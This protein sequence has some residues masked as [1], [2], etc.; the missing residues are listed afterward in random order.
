[1]VLLTYRQ[2]DDDAQLLHSAISKAAT[3]YGRNT[4]P[5]SDE[6]PSRAPADLSALLHAM[7]GR[8]GSTPSDKVNAIALL[9]QKRGSHNFGN[10]TL[11]IYDFM[12]P[13][14]VWSG[15][16][17]SA[18]S[19][20][21]EVYDLPKYEYIYNELKQVRHTPTVQLLRLFPHPSR[22]HWF[23]SWTQ[24]QQ[25]PDVSVK[26][27]DPA[28]DM[29]FSLRIMSGRVYRGCSLVLTQ[30]PTPERKSVYH[31]FMGGKNASLVATVP[32]I[33]LNVNPRNKYVLVDISPDHSLWP[34]EL[35]E[36][37]KET[38]IGHEHLPIWRESVIMVCEE[39]DSLQSPAGRFS[40]SSSAIIKYYLR[41]VT[42]L[43][44]E[45]RVLTKVSDLEWT[46]CP[47]RWLPF[48]PS[49]EHMRSVVCSA[50]GRTHTISMGVFCDPAVVSGLP[51]NKGGREWDRC[52][53]YEV[54]LV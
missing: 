1:M 3:L 2:V 31:C 54:Y 19:T 23:P 18:A 14:A 21:M 22:D 52:P 9:F 15:F 5:W 44:W 34:S 37:C 29:D 4:E 6:Q 40:K 24:V 13:S 26:D 25:F 7:Y 12:P 20:E 45:C 30:P 53:V 42:T 46:Y 39:V 32:G 50:E 16:I 28:G 41:R 8:F 47:R 38:G 10:V 49:L 17:S 33:E 36:C 11:P 35:E 48:K 51:V 43:E 27:T